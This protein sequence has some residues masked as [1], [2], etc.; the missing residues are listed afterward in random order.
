LKI[1]N[2]NAMDNLITYQELRVKAIKDG[3][4]DNKVTIGVWAKLNKYYQIRK[5]VDNK[6]QIFYFKY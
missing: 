4:Q 1:K 2:N 6:V 5:K 3:V